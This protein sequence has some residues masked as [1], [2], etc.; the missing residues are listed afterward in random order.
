MP[1]N[2]YRRG[3]VWYFRA[4]VGGQRI[5]KTLRT[6]S[7]AEAKK[8]RN[9]T[10]DD[11][12]HVRFYG[13]NR[14]TWKETAGR[15]ISEAPGHIKPSALKRYIVSLGQVRHI[16]DDLYI[17]Q[18]SRRTIARIA[19]RK[20]VTNA[21]K[22]RDITAVSSVLRHCVA[23]GWRD[24]NPAKDFDRSI[25]RERRDPIRPPTD[26]EIVQ[27][28]TIAPR[29]I[30]DIARFLK[31]T[32]MRQ[33]EAVGLGWPSVDLKSAEVL[34]LHTKTNRPRVVPLV[35]EAAKLLSALPRHLTSPF[36]FFH[37]D[38]R[39]Y[40]NFASR[41]AA[42]AKR[43]GVGFRCHDLRHRFAIDYL[44]EHGRNALPRLSEILGHSSVRTT[45]IYV[46]YVGSE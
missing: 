3:T 6:G 15:W 8:R 20:G 43:A 24:D 2:L 10:L 30:A 21:T 23:W 14:H 35:P 9:K 18:I 26:A 46:A 41:F 25:I 12:A 4:Q 32:G 45:E 31:L 40:K 11:I 19:G 22:R 44:R 34:L 1:E 33:E 37:G 7:F 5:R 28:C 42:I 36:V 27:Y 38:G 13:D 16:L 39:R 29:G 17:D